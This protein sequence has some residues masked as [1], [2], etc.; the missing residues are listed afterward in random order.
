M[1]ASPNILFI[2]ADQHR[3]DYLGCAGADFAR[4][5]NLDAI[6]ARGIRFDN[7][8]TN[9]PVCAP[10]RIGL[11]AGLQPGRLG[12]LDNQSYLPA[13]ARTYYQRLRDAGYR[14][15]CSG[16]LDL[17]KPDSW[18]STG[19]RPC[20]F[21]FGFTH[22]IEIEGKMHSGMYDQPQ[23]PYGLW[24][25]EQGLYARY[26]KD[27][28]QRSARR[29]IKGASHDSVLPAHAFQDTYIG[30]RAVQWLREIGDDFPWHMFVSFAGPHDPFDPPTV[31]AEHFRDADVPPAIEDEYANKPG[32]YRG[33]TRG[34]NS[35][36]T[37]HARRQYCASIEAI[38]DQ[39]GA[40]LAV[41][42][43]RGMLE[44]TYILYSSDHGEMLGDHGLYTKSVPYEP[45][46][47]VP[48]IIAGPE[49]EGGR[50]SEA[51]VELIDLNATICELAGL[52][53][54]EWI[55]ARSLGPVL[56]GEREE[57][58]DTVV[59]QIRNW[60]LIRT[61]RDK[62]VEHYND[63]DELYDLE[64]DPDELRNLALDQPQRCREL[65]RRMRERF[66]EGQWRR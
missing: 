63:M 10:A 4:T 53:P 11:A 54:Q 30:Q 29:W 5:P 59:S 34:L 35:D 9:C 6:G 65:G 7:C 37:A 50:T 12:S 58:R 17:A 55:D 23:G 3:H 32:W 36:E 46:L 20:V 22:P 66:M 38:D 28:N 51:L 33:R 39:V 57:H 15:G 21:T 18:D 62:Y 25:Q 14:V 48:L 26:R 49:I 61:A 47:H 42:E 24:L 43:E 40:M 31:Y 16:K 13:T 60:R 2:I 1:A 64:E 8:F 52:P 56:R 44:N 19:D 45:S 41:L 27:Y